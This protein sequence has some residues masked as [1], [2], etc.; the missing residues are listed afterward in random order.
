[1]PFC[2]VGFY[3]SLAFVKNSYLL[4]ETSPDPG[5]LKARFLIKSAIPVGFFLLALQGFAL[6]L[7]SIQKLITHTDDLD[8]N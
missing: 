3:E 8:N 7:R 5:G 2:W 1:M 4:N 6:L